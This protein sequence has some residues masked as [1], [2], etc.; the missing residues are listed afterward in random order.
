L[1][2]LHLQ[3]E[4]PTASMPGAAPTDALHP[5]QSASVTATP[6]AASVGPLPL[7]LARILAVLGVLASLLGFAALGGLVP[8]GR[9]HGEEIPA[10]YRSMLVSVGK[11]KH[12]AVDGWI[13]DVES[14][15]AL[16]QLADHYDRL[17]LHQR[18]PKG[19]SYLVE[20]G[21]VAY[22]Y[23][24]ETPLPTLSGEEVPSIAPTAL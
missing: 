17:I 22:R 14:F 24:P 2:E 7:G 15:R 11:P 9:A 5:A 16:A 23:T 6:G 3:L 19:E 20:E 13:V 1:D 4:Q 18:H 10:R 8:L 12:S 21:G